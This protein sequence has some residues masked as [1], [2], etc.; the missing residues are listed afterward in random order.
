M[1]SCSQTDHEP[2]SSG[3]AVRRKRR[4]VI[5][6][7]LLSV[8]SLL[9]ACCIAEL[10]LRIFPPQL[11]ADVLFRA[12]DRSAF[13][14]SA[15]SEREHPWSRGCS[16]VLKIA[17]IGDSFTQG[18][19]VQFDD[20][21]AARLERMLNMNTNARPVEVRVFSEPGTST[22]QQLSLLKEAL[23]WQPDICILGMCL[24]DTEDWT[25]PQELGAWR[26]CCLP[27]T[28]PAWLARI[29]R[30]SMLL[31]LAYSKEEA[32]RTR[33]GLLQYYQRIYDRE[34]SGWKR[35]VKAVHAFSAGCKEAGCR[36]LVVI[37]PLLDAPFD[38]GRY[39]YEKMHSAI[40]STLDG[41]DIPYI[42]L[43]DQFRGKT[44]VRM[45][46]TPGIDQHPGEIAHRIAAETIFEQLLA[47]GYIGPEYSLHPRVSAQL[48]H[49][50]WLQAARLK[51]PAWHLEPHSKRGW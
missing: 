35:W 41:A 6:C 48:W 30:S 38:A 40:R 11:G 28:P 42:D 5:A 45:V 22:Y 7:V 37:F 46:A 19:G 13:F 4:T 32:F 49:K 44:P 12:M 18:E 34:Y 24:N 47:R 15:D 33:H 27:R 23:C 39:P 3:G 43:L 26:D 31:T 14:Y 36:L 10:A 2:V 8:V 20:R 51:T 16:N 17:V 29:I 21:Y 25:R 1:C 9:V 50:R